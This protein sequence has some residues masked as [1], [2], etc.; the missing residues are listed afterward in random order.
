MKPTETWRKN[1][2]RYDLRKYTRDFEKKFKV[3]REKNISEAGKVYAITYRSSEF[4]TD[5]HHVT[6]LIVSF[7]RF[8]DD[9]GKTYVRGLNLLFLKTHQSIEI[10]EDVY[11]FLN[12]KG[13]EK[14]L[15]MIALHEKYIR[16]YP[17]LF[18]NFEEKKIL[19]QCEVEASE[20]GMIPLLH[21][22]LW[23]TFNPVALD[24]A[25]QL[26]NTVKSKYKPKKVKK[27]EK[28]EEEETEEEEVL[29]E[30]EEI[31]VDLN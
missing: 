7:G 22:N 4:L 9:E 14:S 2:W 15:K 3:K 28:K 25:F 26:E 6:P 21:K 13:D 27:E 23:G 8:K 20:W 16:I 19:T 5:R 17:Y 11:S 18:K 1:N 24:E 30:T 31:S 12:L 29:E 10:L